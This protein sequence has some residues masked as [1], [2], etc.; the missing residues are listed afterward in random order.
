MEHYLLLPNITSPYTRKSS[1][2]SHHGRKAFSAALCPRIL[3][4]R[5]FPREAMILLEIQDEFDNF[6]DLVMISLFFLN[7]LSTF[8]HGGH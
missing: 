8:L 6:S 1:K 3:P 7:K 2:L 4:T 5:A